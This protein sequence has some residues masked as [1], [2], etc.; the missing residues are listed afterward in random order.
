[1]KDKKDFLLKTLEEIINIDSPSGFCYSAVKRVAKIAASLGYVPKISNKGGIEIEIKGSNNQKKIGVAAHL[2]TLGAQISSI[3][4]NGTIK[5]AQVGGLNLATVDGEYCRIYTRDGK[6]YTGTFLHNHAS[7]HVFSDAA[8]APRDAKNMYI[9]L[10]ERV[11]NAGDVRSLGIEVGDF[12][13]LESKFTATHSGYIKSRFLDDKAS[14]AIILA[15]L[16]EFSQQ[17]TQPKYDTKIIFTTYEE[18]GHGASPFGE[19]L[20]EVL[21]VDMGC[22]GGE[23]ACTE[24]DVSI[25]A[26]DISGPY[27]YELTTRLIQ[28]AKKHNLSYAVD[29]YPFYGSDVSA[30]LRAG[31][32]IKGGLIGAGIHASHGMERTHIDGLLNTY[33]LLFAY[34]TN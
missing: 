25:C 19:G 11:E 26:K 23:L 4:S 14:V 1:M 20:E 33:K 5:F 27:D 13:A 34:L 22:V 21:A 24:H 30:M 9:R 29:I 32:D 16:N 2:D 17:K 6:V 3:G 7:S 31:R 8:T 10:D 18:V 12:I 28:L 15:V